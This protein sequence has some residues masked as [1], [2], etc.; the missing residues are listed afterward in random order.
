MCHQYV[1]D[2]HRHRHRVPGRAHQLRPHERALV[3]RVRARLSPNATT[4]V[5]ERFRDAEDLDGL[6]S[7][8]DTADTRAY[9]PGSSR[10]T[11]RASRELHPAG[12]AEEIK[13][14]SFS[15]RMGFDHRTFR[16]SIGSDAAASALRAEHPAPS[17]RAL[18]ARRWSRGSAAAR[19]SSSCASPRRS[20][21]TPDASGPARSCYAVGWTQHTTGVQI[22][23][24]GRHPAIAARQHGTA[25]RRDHGDA[26]PRQHPGLDRHAHPLRHCCPAT[27]PSRAPCATTTRSTSYLEQEEV[28][29]RLLVATSR[30]SWSAC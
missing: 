1:R 7:G 15:E 14:E 22:I 29:H 11:I 9:D 6:F 19:R 27:F 10:G 26:R 28:P 17:L 4:I 2:P 5:T 16:R 23:R 25:R 12:D 13:A 8:F 24:A 30:S 20:A 18:H 3:P 21:P